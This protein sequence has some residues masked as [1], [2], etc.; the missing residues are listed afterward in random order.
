MF[1][2]PPLIVRSEFSKY[3]VEFCPYSP[4]VRLPLLRMTLEPMNL[5]FIWIFPSVGADVP[6]NRGCVAFIL[7][8]LLYVLEILSL[9]MKE[10]DL[11]ALRYKTEAEE[12]LVMLFDCPFIRFPL[13]SVIPP[14][15][16]IVASEL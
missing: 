3:P 10:P 8:L 1:N 16:I 4:K 9:I 7:I 2:V 14:S 13:N 15:A 12:V 5:P 11:E 6:S